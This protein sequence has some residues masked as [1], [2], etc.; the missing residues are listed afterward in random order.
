MDCLDASIE[1]GRKSTNEG[2]KM[3]DYYFYCI[4]SP[5]KKR[6]AHGVVKDGREGETASRGTV[7]SKV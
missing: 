7:A 2:V 5:A 3:H 4:D 6:G 1:P